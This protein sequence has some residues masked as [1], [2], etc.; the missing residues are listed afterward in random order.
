MTE[1]V[2]A[3]VL[4]CA[5]VFFQDKAGGINGKHVQDKTG[6]RCDFCA[7]CAGRLQCVD[8]FTITLC[9]SL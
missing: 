2:H 4:A 1:G 9:T 7:N 5:C 3:L 6:C 8:S